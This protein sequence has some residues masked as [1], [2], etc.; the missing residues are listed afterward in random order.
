[1]EV[2]HSSETSVTSTGLRSVAYQKI[3]V[4]VRCASAIPF[5]LLL[6]ATLV[7]SNPYNFVAVQPYVLRGSG[8]TSAKSPDSYVDSLL[9]LH[10][11]Y[12]S[13]VKDEI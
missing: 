13:V 8:Q 3:V 12:K 6:T 11:R 2:V 5:C 4:F 10:S 1:M 9:R 7:R